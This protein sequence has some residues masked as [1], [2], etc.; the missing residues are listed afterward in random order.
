MFWLLVGLWPAPWGG[1]ST[2]LGGNSRRPS[3][4]PHTTREPEGAARARG[5]GLGRLPHLRIRPQQVVQPLCLRAAQ[6][7]KGLVPGRPGTLVACGCRFLTRL[8][9]S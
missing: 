5:A 4:R 1:E 2:V 9:H 3:R 7:L 8:C 6:R